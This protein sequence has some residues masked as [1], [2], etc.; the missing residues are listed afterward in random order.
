MCILDFIWIGVAASAFYK[1]RISNLEFHAVPAVL[2][3]LT[4]CA[5]IVFFVNGGV[6]LRWQSV[7][8]AAVDIAWG[9]F[10]TAIAA[11]TGAIIT[12]YFEGA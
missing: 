3:Y 4:Y 2:F 9:C 6:N 11:S 10:V 8:L 5:G 12:R 7:A 1:S